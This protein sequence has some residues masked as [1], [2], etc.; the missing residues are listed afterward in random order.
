MSADL[1]PGGIRKAVDDVV[2]GAVVVAIGIALDLDTDDS[3]STPEVLALHAG[4]IAKGVCRASR[5]GYME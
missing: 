1:E 4:T 3:F 5:V 2:Y